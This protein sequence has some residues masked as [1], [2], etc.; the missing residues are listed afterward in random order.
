MLIVL[1]SV[2]GLSS[3]AATKKTKLQ[4]LVDEMLFTDISY[5]NALKL[6]EEVHLTESLKKKDSMLGWAACKY[7]WL[8]KRFQRTQHKQNKILCFSVIRN[9][10]LS[11]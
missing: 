2:T 9:A 3:E 4:H 5:V 8:L 6:L 1:K 11:I 10:R 7:Y